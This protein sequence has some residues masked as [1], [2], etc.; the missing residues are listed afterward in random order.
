MMGRHFTVPHRHVPI[1][2]YLG[3]C[4]GGLLHDPVRVVLSLTQLRAQHD[5]RD[6]L[7]NN[8]YG[9]DHLIGEVDLTNTGNIGTVVRVRITWPQE[10]YAPI[11]ARKTVRTKPGTTTHTAVHTGPVPGPDMEFCLVGTRGLEPRYPACK[12]GALPLSYAPV[13]SE[14]PGS[15]YRPPGRLR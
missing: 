14:R 6:A 11:T 13:M 3:A 7:T 2:H 1:R 9:N 12:A 15:A 5:L 8:I 10:G 4:S